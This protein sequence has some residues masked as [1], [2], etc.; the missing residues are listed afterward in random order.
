MSTIGILFIYRS[1]GYLFEFD[2]YTGKKMNTEVGLSESVVLSLTVQLNG[3]GCEVYYDN[4]FISLALQ[5]KLMN[6]NTKDCGIVWTK[7]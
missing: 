2:L 6:Q 3:L 4:F 5:Y 1:T 7:I